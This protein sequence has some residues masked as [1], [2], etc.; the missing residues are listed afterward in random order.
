MCENMEDRLTLLCPACDVSR[1]TLLVEV[2]PGYQVRRCLDCGLEFANPMSSNLEIYDRLYEHFSGSQ[3]FGS[4]DFASTLHDVSM[5]AYRSGRPKFMGAGAYYVLRWLLTN[6][7]V[8]CSILDLGCGAGNFLGVMQAR[9]YRAYGLEVAS[10]AVRRLRDKGFSVVQGGIEQYPSSWPDVDAV[11]VQE[12]LEHLPNPAETIRMIA[13]RFPYAK[14][15]V[16]VPSPRS[17]MSR[18][19][20]IPA[21]YPPNHLTRWT[22]TALQRLL[23]GAGYKSQIILPKPAPSEF[24]FKTG[25]ATS[26]G[27]SRGGRIRKPV[28]WRVALIRLL[29]TAKWYVAAPYTYYL[30][31]KGWSSASMVAIA[32][33]RQRG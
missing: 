9:G 12:V 24:S 21:D 23:E 32:S 5:I 1:E 25:I 7:P 11:T 29:A 22:P 28:W 8:G 15:L 19:V 16:T 18:H 4:S 17:W 3:E 30:Y 20:R 13:R 27:R 2:V 10:V 33:P 26:L 14:L 6:L 31:L